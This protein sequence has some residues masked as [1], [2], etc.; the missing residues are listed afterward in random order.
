VSVRTKRV[1]EPPARTDGK[2]Y[3]IDR[4]WPRGLSKET[5]PLD[6]WFKELAPSPELRA[7][8]G[9]DPGKFPVFRGRYRAELANQAEL[10]DRLVVEA[11]SGTVTLLFAA[12]DADHSN[13]AVL[14]ELLE[15]RRR[16]RGK[17][18]PVGR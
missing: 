8:F 15:E 11:A 16:K 3:L 9:H 14:R 7:W 5:L 2:R 12:R 6:G 1:Y 10:L 13:A 18:G 17:E 4:L